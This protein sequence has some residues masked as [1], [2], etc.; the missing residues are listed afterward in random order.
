[1]NRIVDNLAPG[2]ENGCGRLHD[3]GSARVLSEY[4][5]LG[6]QDVGS[7]RAQLV[8]ASRLITSNEPYGV[9]ADQFRMLRMRLQALGRLGKMKTVMVTSALSGEGKTFSALNL[10]VVLAEQGGTVLLV[11]ADL[12]SPSLVERLGIEPWPGL[13][14]CL[15]GGFDPVSAVRYV[16]PLGV[17]MLPAGEATA[18]ATRLLNADTFVK[19][20]QRL[21]TLA[22]WVILD[23]PP[24]LAMP[25]VLAIR[26]NVDGCLV[27]VRANST[28]RDMVKD[29]IHQVGAE[30][31][32]GVV[33]NN[34]EIKDGYYRYYGAPDHTRA[35]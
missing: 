11:E 2:T 8:P 12:R 17:Y 27:V 24:A 5:T 15:D 18:S 28:P 14:Q 13:A 16:N 29:T 6:L 7:V 4:G 21:R 22:D 32:I 3:P 10:A 20:M 34:A 33:F 9:E 31:V 35:Q 26:G 23:C 25:D 30:F 1:M 19:A